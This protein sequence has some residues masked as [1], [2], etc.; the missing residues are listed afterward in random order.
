MV[1]RRAVQRP[2]R[3]FAE[4]RIFPLATVVIATERKS[5]LPEWCYAILR[6]VFLRASLHD[7]TVHFDIESGRS[8]GSRQN[9]D[10]WRAGFTWDYVYLRKIISAPDRTEFKSWCAKRAEDEDGQGRDV[11]D[12]NVS[13]VWRSRWRGGRAFC[14]FFLSRRKTTTTGWYLACARTTSCS[15]ATANGGR[16][17]YGTIGADR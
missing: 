7:G 17:L 5:R 1:W 6:G 15:R 4:F 14:I 11:P 8:R 13:Y 9:N 3:R 10:V 16:L 2:Q 12:L